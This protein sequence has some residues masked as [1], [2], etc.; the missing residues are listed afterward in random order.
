MGPASRGFPSLDTLARTYS[1]A[2]PLSAGAA[3][4]EREA[5]VRKRGMNKKGWIGC[6]VRAQQAI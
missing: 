1:T 5:D 4:R 2:T 6:G 3:T